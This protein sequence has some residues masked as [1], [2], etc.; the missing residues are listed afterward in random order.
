M[1][2]NIGDKF[3]TKTGDIAIVLGIDTEKQLLHLRIFHGL[4]TISM[5]REESIELTSKYFEKTIKKS[6]ALKFL[7]NKI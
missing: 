5:Y 3:N 1:D 7:K 6:D 4:E 2:I